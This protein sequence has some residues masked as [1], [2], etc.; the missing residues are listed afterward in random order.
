MYEFVIDHEASGRFAFY[1]EIKLIDD[2]LVVQEQLAKGRVVARRQFLT[3]DRA[4][5]YLPITRARLE[6]SRGDRRSE[7]NHPLQ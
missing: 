7:T 3:G 5:V 6:I 1:F 4:V 2:I